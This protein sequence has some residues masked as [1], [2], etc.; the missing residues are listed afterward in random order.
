M[1]IL[2][3]R[4]MKMPWTT[5]I[6]LTANQKEILE[7][8]CKDCH[9]KDDTFKY[10]FIKCRYGEYDYILKI[11]SETRNQAHQ[12]GVWFVNKAGQNNPEDRVKVGDGLLYWVKLE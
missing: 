1:D 6:G 10:D 11:L 9:M 12:R 4:R 5:K 8:I 2:P 7:Q 3:R